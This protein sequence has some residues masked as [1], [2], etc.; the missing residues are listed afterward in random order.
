MSLKRATLRPP[1]NCRPGPTLL[2]GRFLRSPLWAGA[3]E[4][5]QTAVEADSRKPSAG[6]RVFPCSQDGQ[7]EH[8][9]AIKC[10][11]CQIVV[12]AGGH[13]TSTGA[14]RIAGCA[15]PGWAYGICTPRRTTRCVVPSNEL[16]IP[17]LWSWIRLRYLPIH[18]TQNLMLHDNHPVTCSHIERT[19]SAH[20]PQLRMQSFTS[21]PKEAPVR[22]LARR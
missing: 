19:L 18:D 12:S 21:R 5:R 7:H 10:W 11:L 3:G 9:L 22:N 1:S 17:T 6:A 2:H 4:H 15:E 8:R 13:A 16:Q 14:N 20:K